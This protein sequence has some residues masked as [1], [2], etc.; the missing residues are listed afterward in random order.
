M[1]DSPLVLALAQV[2]FPTILAINDPAQI[3]G[4]QE[5]I[6]KDF[7]DYSSAI[8]SEPDIQP[9]A[10]GMQIAV[11]RMHHFTDEAGWTISLCQDFMALSTKAVDAYQSKDDFI[12]RL[13]TATKSL[14]NHL[15]PARVTRLGVRFANRVSDNEEMRNLK[16]FIH[17]DFL[18]PDVLRRASDGHPQIMSQAVASIR[19][20]QIRAHWGFLAPNEQ[21]ATLSTVDA[22]SCPCWMLDWDVFMSEPSKD[23]NPNAIS[24]KAGEF[25][26]RTY[27]VF[28][29]VFLPKFIEKHKNGSRRHA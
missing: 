21:I 27:A 5:G 6:R 16:Q 23:F 25:V 3:A 13:K 1:R 7:P 12:K 15:K 10:G 22:L 4:F 17:A 14:H 11:S 18:G 20:G 9:V 8:R 19:E 28:R 26:D 29:H 2:R 24:K